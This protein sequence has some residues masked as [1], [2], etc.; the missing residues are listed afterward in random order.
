MLGHPTKKKSLGLCIAKGS[1]RLLGFLH[2]LGLLELR[3]CKERLCLTVEMPECGPKERWCFSRGAVKLCLAG[4]LRPEG[5]EARIGAFARRNGAVLQAP[6]AGIPQQLGG[7]ATRG[8][9]GERRCLE[10]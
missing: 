6:S 8:P 9:P 7:E 2:L 5:S 1:L 10:A 4:E 3:A